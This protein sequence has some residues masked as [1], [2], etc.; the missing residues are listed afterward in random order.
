MAKVPVYNADGAKAGTMD[1][2]DE[3]FGVK[4][5][6]RLV[7][8]AVVTQL[9]NRRKPI[10]HTLTKSEVRG[11]GRKHW[12]QKGTGRARHGSIRSPL[13]RGGGVTFG[14]RSNRNFS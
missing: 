12:R 3:I 10:A 4:I 11:G 13:W 6:P 1:V 5:D 9:A 7:Q 8:Q 2:P 14:P